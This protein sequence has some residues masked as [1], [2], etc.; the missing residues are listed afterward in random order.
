[1]LNQ[2]VV[3]GKIIYIEEYNL[4]TDNMYIDV[5]VKSVKDMTEDNP[6]P[7]Y[8]NVKMR[9]T[10]E[11]AKHIYEECGEGSFVGVKG[12]IDTTEQDGTN[13][14]IMIDKMTIGIKVDPKE[15][16]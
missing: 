3:V 11:L 7:D 16:E 1:M 4:G 12:H 9:A 15:E 13:M 2:V 5:L 10:G 14:I 6:E 8:V